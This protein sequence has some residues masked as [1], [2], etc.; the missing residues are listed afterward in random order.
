MCCTVQ[1]MLYLCTPAIAIHVAM[2]DSAPA[3]ESQ[4]GFGRG[5]GRGGRGRGRRGGRG[6]GG[7]KEAKDV[8]ASVNG[9]NWWRFS[10]AMTDLL[11][12]TV[13]PHNQVR[14]PGQ[15]WEDQV[16]RRHLHVCHANQGGLAKVVYSTF[17]LAVTRERLS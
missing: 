4:G 10:T 9:R 8:S 17:G 1:M 6:R 7:P 5:R 13:G 3:G 14:S 16:F 15:G 2:A 12:S 11:C